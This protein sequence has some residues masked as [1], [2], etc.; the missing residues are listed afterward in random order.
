MKLL[1][2]IK[3]RR[4]IMPSQYNDMPIDDE[5]IKLI[6]EAANWAPTHKKTEP[7]RFK[8]LRG[9]SKNNLGD[10]LAEKYK[11]KAPNF[12]EFKQKKLKEKAIKSS[13]IILIC[14]QRDPLESVPE[15]EEIASVSMAV[16]NMWL[17]ASELSIGSYWSSPKLI[18]FIHEF[19]PLQAGERCL[20]IFYMGSHDGVI[21]S[22]EP[23]PIADKV[24]WFE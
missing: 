1:D 11:E 16:Q 17:M 4:S 8:V 14:M 18:D 9:E 12:S 6:I 21:N 13:A 2:L 10:F 24:L 5:Q 23:S 15:W 19:I 22:R 20:G 7:W 3:S